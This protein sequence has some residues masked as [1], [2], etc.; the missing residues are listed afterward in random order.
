[1]LVIKKVASSAIPEAEGHVIDSF[2][3]SDNKHTNAPSINAVENY[4]ASTG[5]H[6]AKCVCKISTSLTAGTAWAKYTFPFTAEHFA[7]DNNSM[8]EFSDNGIK[9]K[10]NGVLLILRET[11]NN[12]V[13]GEF[14]LV[15]EDGGSAAIGTGAQGIKTT[16]VIYSCSKGDTIKFTYGVATTGTYD[17]YITK[18]HVICLSYDRSSI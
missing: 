9:C 13:S 14:D 2:N 15:G 18:L 4:I 11:S 3:T 8:F 6:Y 10:F 16:N 5:L 17:W 1:M 7:T 12:Y